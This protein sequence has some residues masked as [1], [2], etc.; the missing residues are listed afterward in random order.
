MKVKGTYRKDAPFWYPRRMSPP[1]SGSVRTE[2]KK[3]L[4]GRPVISVSGNHD[5]VSLGRLL[6]EVGVY[7]WDL[8]DGPFVVGDLVFAGYR[9]I[10]YLIGEWAGE[11]HD[12][13]TPVA[14]TMRFDPDVLVT[15]APPGGVLDR[16]PYAKGKCGSSELTT[17][18]TYKPHKV[19]LHLFGHVHEDPGRTEK[20][21]IIFSNAAGGGRIIEV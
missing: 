21:G 14:N 15:H 12:M 11:T 2:I 10:P 3:W 9:E 19:K 6:Q 17:W 8:A 20:M 13:Q 7:S 16:C 1:F 4:A 5:Y 18:L